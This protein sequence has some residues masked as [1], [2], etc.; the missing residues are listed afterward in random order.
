VVQIR[1]V[2]VA[3]EQVKEVRADP[4]NGMRLRNPHEPRPG[5]HCA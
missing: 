1:F 5:S 2:V 4:E 3:A